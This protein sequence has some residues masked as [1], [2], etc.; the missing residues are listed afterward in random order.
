MTLTYPFDF[1]SVY[2]EKLK[3]TSF[4]NDISKV[5]QE[6]VLCDEKSLAAPKKPVYQLLQNKDWYIYF[7]PNLAGWVI[8]RKDELEANKGGYHYKSKTFSCYLQNLTKQLFC[9]IL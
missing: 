9:L 1:F 4:E 5:E 2:P 6:F 3:S 7:Y 8:G